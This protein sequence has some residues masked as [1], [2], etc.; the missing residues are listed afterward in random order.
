M[1]A[2]S[3]ATLRNPFSNEIEEYI[4][5]F[6]KVY[7]IAKTNF[8]VSSWGLGAIQNKTVLKFLNEFEESSVSPDDTLDQV[9]EELTKLLCHSLPTNEYIMGFHI[10]GYMANKDTQIPQLRHIFHETWHKAGQL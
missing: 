9:S 7:K 2:D 10:A 3:V 6:Q 1:A 5:D 8:G 4:D